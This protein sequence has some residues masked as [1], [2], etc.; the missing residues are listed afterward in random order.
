[1]CYDSCATCDYG[2]DGN[3]NNCTK[4]EENYIKNPDYPNSTECIGKCNYYYYY[5]YNQYKCTKDENCPQNYNFFIK[6]K[7]KCIDICKNDNLYQYQYNG[8]CVKQCPND[9]ISD[10]NDFKCKDIELNKCKLSPNEFTNLNENLTD[11]EI[12]YLAK[13]FSQEFEYTN[14]HISIYNNEVYTITLYKNYECIS[15]LNLEI[16]E[17][18]FGICYE[19]VKNDYHIDDN[20]VIAIITKKFEGKN[21]NKM[22]SYSMYDPKNGNKL[23]SNDIC[24]DDS[25]IVQENLF[26]K[27]N[28]TKLNTDI[29]S[30]LYLAE[31]DIDIFNISSTFYVDICYHFDS[32]IDKD[33]ALKDRILIYYPN[34][35]LCENGCQTKGVNL[36][37]FKAIC[38]CTLNNLIGNNIFENNV[39]YQSSLGEIQNFI[40][41]TNI[42]VIKCYKDIFVYNYVFSSLGGYIILFLLFSQV[43]LTIIYH[44]KTSYLLR[45]YLFGITEQYL[46]FLYSNKKNAQNNYRNSIN[47]FNNKSIKNNPV[48]KKKKKNINEKNNDIRKKNQKIKQKKNIKLNNKTVKIK[49]YINYNIMNNYSENY[50]FSINGSISSKE[51]SMDKNNLS[52]KNILEKNKSNN[53]FK[54]LNIEEYLCTE[55]ND[56]DYDDAI[57]KDKRTFCEYFIERLK[58]NQIN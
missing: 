46:S 23:P 16:P 2:G 42:E 43:I 52:N 55:L 54:Y 5:K 32:P 34:I 1:M 21:Y 4:C 3:E 53:E 22:I 36:T 26:F 11:D 10:D 47:V 57:K 25:F 49:K 48:K 28:N 18:D 33:I 9:T 38:E 15:E 31:Q 50:K 29:D 51:I 12:T 35:T 6:E 58:M 44:C 24:K 7:G 45:K 40:S 13:K 17:I 30:L 8:K 27:L 19:K 56:M 39:L 37:T 14:N 20:L 41:Q